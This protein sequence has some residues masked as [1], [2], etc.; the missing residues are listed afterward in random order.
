MSNQHSFTRDDHD[1]LANQLF[2]LHCALTVVEQDRGE[3]P[4]MTTALDRAFSLVS[5]LRAGLTHHCIL[6]GW[7]PP[8]F[9]SL[10]DLARRLGHAFVPLVPQAQDIRATVDAKASCDCVRA[11]ARDLQAAMERVEELVQKTPSGRGN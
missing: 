10:P 11:T 8:Y 7:P 3:V 6:G 9:D 2:G 5:A 1:V 4:M